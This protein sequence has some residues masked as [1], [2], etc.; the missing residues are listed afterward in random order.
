M[1]LAG[2]SMLVSSLA[3]K[4]T[5]AATLAKAGGVASGTILAGLSS[6]GLAL[7]SPAALGPAASTL[8]PLLAALDVSALPAAATAALP[9]GAKTVAVVAGGATAVVA[10]P[11]VLGAVGFTTSGI[12]ASSIAA[13]MMS[14]TAIAN[15]GGVPAGSMVAAL[16]SMGAAGLSASAKGLVGTVGSALVAAV[17]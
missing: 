3:S 17:L 8:G 13:K 15:G 6:K 7:L 4:I 12:A 9:I 16:Q 2:A 10:V 5:A 14:I 11:L 1:E